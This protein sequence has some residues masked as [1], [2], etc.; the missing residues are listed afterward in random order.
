MVRALTLAASVQSALGFSALYL[1]LFGCGAALASP[2]AGLWALVWMRQLAVP[3]LLLAVA[4]AG[5]AI[6]LMAWNTLLRDQ[7][8]RN[9][10]QRIT[11]AGVDPHEFYDIT[12]VIGP[13]IDGITVLFRGTNGGV[14]NFLFMCFMTAGVFIVGLGAL[15]TWEI[16]ARYVGRLPIPDLLMPDIGAGDRD[17]PPF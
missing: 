2:Q 3:L 1:V 14:V 10:E 13:S 8:L 16:I 9:A 4:G 12:G 17:D 11:D 7:Q 15:L 5:L 6:L